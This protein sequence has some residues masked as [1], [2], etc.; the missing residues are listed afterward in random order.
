[1]DIGKLAEAVE[2]RSVNGILGKK[3]FEPIS[4]VIRELAGGSFLVLAAGE[5]RMEYGCQGGF[6]VDQVLGQL[7]AKGVDGP[8]LEISVLLPASWEEADLKKT[9]RGLKQEM[10]RRGMED[11]T[12]HARVL[13]E[14]SAPV[15]AVSGSGLAA[16]G[17]APGQGAG[18]WDIGLAA[19]CTQAGLVPGASIVMA[20]YA[21]LEATACII[22]AKR[23]IL[24]ERLPGSYLEGGMEKALQTDVRKAIRIARE[25]GALV[26][27]AGEGGI[28]NA[29]WGLGRLLDCGMELS[30]RDILL[31]QETIEVC[32]ILDVNPYLML[33]AGS[34][35]AVTKQPEKLL[36]AYREAGIPA[37]GIG[38]LAAGHDRFLANGL[39]QRFLEPFR[40][41][42]IFKSGILH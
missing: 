9:I 17:F 36:A 18:G 15:L 12:V 34:I 29:L 41:D 42:E 24:L 33:S 32:E 23:E 19:G 28:F 2:G 30:L 10:G 8:V 25:Y 4:T 3:R 1:M 20:G 16:A 22:H 26:R 39:D 27:I 13:G 5:A 38:R 7:C 14:I 35:L 40:G 11:Y 6:L 21:A 37:A 31:L